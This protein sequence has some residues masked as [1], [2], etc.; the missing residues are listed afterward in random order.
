MRQYQISGVPVNDGARRA[1]LRRIWQEMGTYGASREELQEWHEKKCSLPHIR[2]VPEIARLYDALPH[3]GQGCCDM[4]EP[5]IIVHFP[6]VL[7]PEG[8][9]E[10]PLDVPWCPHQDDV[11]PWAEGRE[12]SHIIGVALTHSGT[13]NGGLI[14]WPDGPDTPLLERRAVE[15]RPGHVVS[16]HPKAWH[17]GTW[18]RGC[19]PRVVVY[20]RFLEPLRG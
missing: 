4:C 14:M 18:N 1:A 5:Q 10:N 6:D 11:P 17:S 16:I 15:V 8:I 3:M 13:S 12:Y 2:F 20:F 9:A 7:P 19:K